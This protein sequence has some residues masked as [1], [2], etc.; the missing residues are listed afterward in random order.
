MQ[1]NSALFFLVCLASSHLLL[2][3]DA[4]T[5]PNQDPSNGQASQTLAH[6][7]SSANVDQSDRTIAER[8]LLHLLDVNATRLDLVPISP[9]PRSLY[10]MRDARRKHAHA[11]TTPTLQRRYNPFT[12]LP[13]GGQVTWDAFTTITP[14]I[15]AAHALITLLTL[16]YNEVLDSWS[17]QPPRETSQY[18]YGALRLTF[19]RRDQVIPWDFIAD[20][21]RKMGDAVERG[22]LGF[23]QFTFQFTTAA[24][25]VFAIT[26]VGLTIR[27]A[28][29]ALSARPE[30]PRFFRI[31]E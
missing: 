23:V 26:V 10:P 17:R 13:G 5:L 8:D 15:I 12:D 19:Y 29:T 21:A 28:A 20:I 24:S 14:S 30:R 18:T 6:V 22:L 2:V 31:E 1:A 16:A 4:R 7:H 9:S 27:D 25:V 3:L 11:P